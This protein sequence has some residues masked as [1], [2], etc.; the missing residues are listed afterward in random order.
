MK[1]EKLLTR[2]QFLATTALATAAMTVG[3]Y[4]ETS[5]SAGKLSVGL[6][7]H[8]VPGANKVS[9]KIIEDWAKANHIDITIDY[10]TSMGGKQLVTIAAEA[11]AKTGHDV[12]D[13][14][15]VQ[16]ALHRDS[17]EPMDDVVNEV[18]SQY[19]PLSPD[20]EYLGK[21][22]GTWYSAPGP[23][24]SHTYPMVSRLDLWK[25]YAGIDLKKIFPASPDRDPELVKSWNYDNFLEACKKLHKAGY[26]FGNP[27]GATSDSQDWLGPLFMSFGSMFVNEKGEI[28]VDSDATRQAL[29][30]MKKLTQ[31]MPPEVYAWDDAS[32]NR[33][34]ISG[35]GSAIQNPPSAWA[36]AVRDKPDIAKQI[37]HHDTPAGPKGRFRGSL[38][39]MMGVWNFSK[40]KTA[41]KDL[42]L[43]LLQKEQQYKLIAA[44]K[45]YD[46]PLIKA[47]TAHPVWEEASPP[48]GT[49]YNY[50][51]RG[52]EFQ[53]MCGYPAPI[54]IAAQIYSQATIPNTVAKV[55]QEGAS[56]D[57]AIKWAVNELEGY[58]RG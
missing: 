15:T 16:T 55:T 35:R 1:S 43:H 45:G 49:L 31:Y 37:W 46:V 51:V 42:I 18:I 41:G 40:N 30:Y 44:S 5:Y 14:P 56:I 50:P 39:R 20:A 27:I 12:M 21:I 52:D 10:I 3:P 34:I 24:G 54:T 58:M 33:W 9:R 11:R 2:R 6:W 23:I 38:P 26:P 7:D 22:E 47:F 28:T 19:G 32:N 29:E 25:K 57:E 17:L 8:W 4:V 13:F 48:L 53:M 36:V